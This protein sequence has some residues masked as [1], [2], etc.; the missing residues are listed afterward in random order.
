[1]MFRVVADDHPKPPCSVSHN[2]EIGSPFSMYC[3]TT[4]ARIR[5]ERSGNRDKWAHAN[6]NEVSCH[7]NRD[8]YT[9]PCFV[10]RQGLGW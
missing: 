1:M 7:C 6:H 5:R 4:P 10:S 8:H 3:L 9:S 2:D